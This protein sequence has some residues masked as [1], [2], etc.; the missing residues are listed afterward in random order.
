MA[1]TRGSSIMITLA[2]GFIMLCL[3][4]FAIWI[5][6]ILYIPLVIAFCAAVSF[7]ILVLALFGRGIFGDRKRSE[8]EAA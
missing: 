7:I 2:L 8:A 6:T 3:A 5:S 1:I 4:V